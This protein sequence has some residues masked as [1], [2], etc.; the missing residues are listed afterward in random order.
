MAIKA[1][2][3]DLD[4]TLYD[5]NEIYASVYKVMQQTVLELPVSFSDF[6][7]IYQLESIKWYQRFMSQECSEEDYQIQRVIDTYD[8]FGEKVRFADG[9]LFNDLY[10]YF[11]DSVKLR[12]FMKEM[13][14][15]VINRDLDLFI[16]TNGPSANQW[17]KIETLQLDRWFKPD[18]LF[19]SGDLGLTKPD[20]AIFDHLADQM[21]YESNELLY[22]GDHYV[23]D[24]KGAKEAGWQAI[25]FDCFNQGP[26]EEAVPTFQTEQQLYD[27]LHRRFP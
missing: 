10:V 3:F 27:Y 12:P 19:V 18:R 14:Q 26:L 1:V 22:I 13:I 24:I 2:G 15:L 17:H 11:K 9:K 25:Y 4:D 6:N 7:E 21:G 16:L 23:N 5:R 8:H 20:R